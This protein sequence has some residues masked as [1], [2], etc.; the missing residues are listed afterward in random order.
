[1]ARLY[2]IRHGETDWNIENRTQG[3]GN[4]LPL[5]LKGLEQARAVAQKLKDMPAD[6]LYSSDLKRAYQTALEI[7]K[8]TGLDIHVTDKLREMNFGC[9]EGLT[10]NEIRLKYGSIYSIWT[11]KPIDVNI[12]EGESII[13]LQQR[14][15]SSVNE[16]INCHRGKNIIIVSHGMCLKVLLL[17]VLNMDIS[18]YNRIRLDNTGISIIEY[19]G[20]KPYLVLMNDTCHLR[21]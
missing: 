4:D 21:R 15:V 5:N 9:W 16:I 19:G 10:T 18:L 3:C 6:V 1:M 8:S 14:M 7:S 13:M 2:L 11:S 12:P 17:S 20:S